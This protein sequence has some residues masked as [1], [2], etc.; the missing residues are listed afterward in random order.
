MDGCRTGTADG[1]KVS[2]IMSKTG[3]KE[4]KKSLSP[5]STGL[6]SRVLAG[7]VSIKILSLLVLSWSVAS[8]VLG[9]IGVILYNMRLSRD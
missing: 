8:K 7:N 3:N 1:K 2:C 5:S 4:G 6:R 9:Y